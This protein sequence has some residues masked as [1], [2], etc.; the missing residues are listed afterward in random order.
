MS[1]P[2]TSRQPVPPLRN[3]A[4]IC[5][6]TDGR[7]DTARS[8]TRLVQSHALGYESRAVLAG[9]PQPGP[10]PPLNAVLARD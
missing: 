1:Q 2:E 7:S 8:R 9:G 10:V 3:T 5:S 6:G 4:G